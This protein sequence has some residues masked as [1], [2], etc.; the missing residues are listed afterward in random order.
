MKRLAETGIGP[1]IKRFLNPCLKPFGHQVVESK[2]LCDYYLHE[3]QSYDDY[4]R[5]QVRHNVRK[6]D[7]IWADERTLERVVQ[8]LSREFGEGTP[9]RG[10]CHG[11]RNGF[12]QNYLM[13]LSSRMSII[14]TDISPTAADY[15]NSLQWDF[16][17]PKEEW[18][19]TSDFVYTNSLDQSWQPK[20]ALTTWLGQLKPNGIL[21]I[22]HTDL[23]GPIG[24]SEMDPFG[25]RP[26]VLPYVLTMWFGH[27]ISIEHSVDRKSDRDLDAWLFVIRKNVNDVSDLTLAN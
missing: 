16:H 19:S 4:R 22:E 14:G 18:V 17:D 23:H 20:I 6:L 5:I 21:I 25:V 12:E 10:I 24:A 13:H 9:I 11:T 15:E 26:T 8:I 1:A 2:G 27:Q 7:S 3:Y